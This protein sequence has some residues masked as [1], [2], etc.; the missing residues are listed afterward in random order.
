MVLVKIL[1]GQQ[2]LT[3]RDHLSGLNISRCF[4]FAMFVLT[5]SNLAILL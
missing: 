4:F 3:W 1:L 2:D 5:K